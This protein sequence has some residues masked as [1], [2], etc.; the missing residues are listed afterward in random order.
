M[1]LCINIITLP[2]SHLCLGCIFLVFGHFRLGRSIFHNYTSEKVNL[3]CSH[4]S[5][6]AL[7][8]NHQM[9]KFC[10]FLDQ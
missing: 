1:G 6:F 2:L 5:L 3:V 7:L 10:D 4:K 9:P 8:Y